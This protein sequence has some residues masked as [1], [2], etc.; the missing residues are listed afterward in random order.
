MPKFVFDDAPAG[1]NECSQ[2]NYWKGEDKSVAE[3]LRYPPTV[4]IVPD[5]NG[6]HIPTTVYPVTEHSRWCG[7]FSRDHSN[8]PYREAE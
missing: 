1:R 5:E 7:E 6:W 2:C 4:V 8:P 3:C